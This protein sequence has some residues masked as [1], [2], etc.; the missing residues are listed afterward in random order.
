MSVVAGRVSAEWSE[1]ASEGAAFHFNLVVG[2]AIGVCTRV[3]LCC[4]QRGECSRDYRSCIAAQVTAGR[5][6]AHLS[7]FQSLSLELRGRVIPE[8][9]PIPP[10]RTPLEMEAG[11]LDSDV[12]ELFGAEELAGDELTSDPQLHWATQTESPS[13][14]RLF[15]LNCCATPLTAA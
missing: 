7:T 2:F 1:T 15:A 8:P 14:V 11:F 13:V 4:A 10:V 5:F 6:Q 3:I 12:Q 9:W